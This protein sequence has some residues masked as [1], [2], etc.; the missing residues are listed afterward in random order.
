MA[1]GSPTST[2]RA[3]SPCA[4]WTAP[5]AVVL[6]KAAAG[7]VRS[8]PSWSRAMIVFAEK[9]PDGTST[10]MA[11]AEANGCDPANGPA[12]EGLGHGHR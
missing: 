6:T 12:T 2:A 10:L 7:V 4:S 11:V 9:R 8:R 3:I 1:A 5:A